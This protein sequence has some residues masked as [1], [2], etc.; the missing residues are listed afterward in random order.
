MLKG[1]VGQKEG[2][3]TLGVHLVELFES[4]L[5]EKRVHQFAGAPLASGELPTEVPFE[6]K[7]TLVPQ[8]FQPANKEAFK[9]PKLMRQLKA[10]DDQA[11]EARVKNYL[12]CQSE[13]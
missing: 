4:E 6:Y 12:H 1:M 3:L 11:Y 9:F 2:H 5:P 10:E 8:Y 7:L 13:Q